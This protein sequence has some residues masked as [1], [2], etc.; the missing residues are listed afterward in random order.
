[1]IKEIKR[2]KIGIKVRD[3]LISI[4][5]YADDIVLMASSKKDLQKMLDIITVFCKKWHCKVNV[6]KSQVVEYSKR[7]NDKKE[8][9]EED[10]KWKLD[11]KE[12]EVVN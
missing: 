1:M 9:K 2:L 5:L 8:S 10:K 4:L 12:M 11:D 7:R 6:K 3:T